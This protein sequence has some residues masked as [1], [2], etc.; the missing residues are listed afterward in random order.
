MTN[1]F[2]TLRL[3]HTTRTYTHTHTNYAL[4]LRLLLLLHYA[5]LFPT[6]HEFR[7]SYL[8]LAVATPFCD[9]SDFIVGAVWSMSDA[10][11]Y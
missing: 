11:E 10:G 5:V 1:L 7:D 8:N 2:L 9:K 3:Q 4:T 6:I